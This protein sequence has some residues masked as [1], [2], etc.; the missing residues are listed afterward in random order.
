MPPV[1]QTDKPAP[2]AEP[3]DFN[4]LLHG[5]R[6]QEL[7]RLPSGARVVLHGGAA[8]KWYF[9][10]SAEA[11]PTPVERHIGVEA[12]SD[13]PPDLPDDVEWL[14]RSLGDLTPVDDG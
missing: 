1:A 11:Y 14:R 5:W 4:L 12:L 3:V 6:T 8:G 2:A 10:W 9:D 7:G 13:A